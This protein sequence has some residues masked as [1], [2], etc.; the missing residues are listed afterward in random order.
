M[1]VYNR[2]PCSDWSI[3]YDVRYSVVYISEIL[4]Q[5]YH[6][7]TLFFTTATANWLAVLPLSRWHNKPLTNIASPYVLVD[8]IASYKIF[9]RIPLHCSA[10]FLTFDRA[11]SKL[12]WPCDRLRNHF[13]ARAAPVWP[14]RRLSTL[15]LKHAPRNWKTQKLILETVMDFPR[16]FAPLK[17]T[18]YTIRSVKTLITQNSWCKWD[19]YIR[20]INLKIFIACVMK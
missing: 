13:I 14:T 1:L 8:V 6:Q 9:N 15:Q 5:F 20:I 16:I 11:A 17:I 19:V 4:Y 7:V 3:F 10:S 18:C 12:I 2:V